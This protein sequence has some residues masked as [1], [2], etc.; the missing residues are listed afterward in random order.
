MRAVNLLPAERRKGAKGP[1]GERSGQKFSKIHGIGLAILLAGG[2]LAYYGHGVSGQAG[3]K[4]L[5]ADDLEASATTLTTQIAAEKAKVQVKPQVSSFDSDKTLVMGLAQA[6][7][8]WSNVIVNLS[9]IKPSTVWLENIKV[10][11]PTSGTSTDAN[12]PTAISLSGKAM[13]RTAAVQFISR[14]NAIP[15]FEEPR[16][17][18]GLNPADLEDGPTTYSFEL[19]IPINDGIFGPVKPKAA[20]AAPAA[21]SNTT[22]PATNQ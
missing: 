16:L 22:T 21:A 7:V 19:E 20:A 4:A 3:Q 9:R 17:I 10:T 14:L 5:E 6:R 11:T 2:A 1:K 12:L 18:G 15:G 13:T 8:N